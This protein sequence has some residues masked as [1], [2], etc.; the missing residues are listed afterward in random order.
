MMKRIAYL[1]YKE[2]HKKLVKV[3]TVNKEFK[4]KLN[5]NEFAYIGRGSNSRLMI[6][7]KLEI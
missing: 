7:E 2:M 6:V 3:D 4:F 5:P 1:T